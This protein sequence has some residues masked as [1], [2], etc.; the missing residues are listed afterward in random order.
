MPRTINCGY[1]GCAAINQSPN[2][3]LCLPLP[4]ITGGFQLYIHHLALLRSAHPAAIWGL[5]HM[6]GGAARTPEWADKPPSISPP[7]L[8]F[9]GS[10]G[11][12]LEGDFS[13][14][15]LF[16]PSPATIPSPTHELLDDITF[17]LAKYIIQ[18]EWLKIEMLT[19]SWTR[20]AVK[21]KSLYL[22][23]I[24]RPAFSMKSPLKYSGLWAW[25]RSNVTF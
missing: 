1:C 15:V 4:S 7:L 2:V 12:S 14:T 3:P 19:W 10:A 9:W 25:A 16:F 6:G 23:C 20:A 22:C 5:N 8:L 11:W 17:T 24:L 13:L 18:A 21:N